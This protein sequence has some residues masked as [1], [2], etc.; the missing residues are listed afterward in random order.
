MPR[1]L[2]DFQ[3]SFAPQIAQWAVGPED[4]DH[5]ASLRQAA[6]PATFAAWHA[7]PDV[8]PRVLLEGGPIAYGELW[9]SSEEDEVEFGRLLVAPQHRGRGVG[10]ALVRALLQEA[11]SP[12]RRNRVGTDRA[13]EQSGAGLLSRRRVRAGCA[14]DRGPVQRAS[15]TSV[16]LA[17]SSA[18]WWCR[19]RILRLRSINR[20]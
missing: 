2:V 10:R 1:E 9:I 11:R 3:L 15:A 16:H 14:R 8:R 17:S 4:L 5:W 6:T 18:G 19:R 12:R 13:R 20:S 7:D